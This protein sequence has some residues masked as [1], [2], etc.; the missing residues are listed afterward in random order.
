MRTSPL[1]INKADETTVRATISGDETA[2]SNC[3]VGNRFRPLGQALTAALVRRAKKASCFIHRPSASNSDARPCSGKFAQCEQEQMVPPRQSRVD[4]SCRP[5][6]AP[7]LNVVYTAA[8][9]HNKNGCRAPLSPP[10]VVLVCVFSNTEPTLSPSNAYPHP[11]VAGAGW[12][13]GPAGISNIVIQIAAAC[14]SIRIE[15]HK[16]DSTQMETMRST[17]G[18]GQPAPVHPLRRTCKGTP[19]QASQQLPAHPAMATLCKPS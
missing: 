15:E 7:F 12:A 14:S 9:P 10:V 16:D 8:L 6:A 3:A 5:C 11:P 17:L 4:P 1:H 2:R 18:L 19:S 13:Q